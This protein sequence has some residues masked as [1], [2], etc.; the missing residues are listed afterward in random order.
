MSLSPRFADNEMIEKSRWADEVARLE[1][2]KTLVEIM[3]EKNSF[4]GKPKVDLKEVFKDKL[5]EYDAEG[6]LEEERPKH[7]FG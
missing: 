7:P 1:V 4:H 3:E 6:N 2:E 5:D